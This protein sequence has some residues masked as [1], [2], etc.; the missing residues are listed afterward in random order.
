MSGPANRPPAGPPRAT[1]R[2]QLNEDFTFRDAARLAPYLAGLGIS[3]VYASPF[4]QARPGSTHGYD[5]TDHNR[6]NEEIGGEAEFENFVATLH[7]HGLGLLLDFVPNHMGIGADNA[8]WFDVLEWG[9]YSPY[10]PFF[11]IDW[12]ASRPDLKGKVLLPVLGGQYGTVLIDGEI[13]LRFDPAEGSISAWYYDHRFPISPGDYA[14]LL[15]PVVVGEEAS[16]QVDRI[17][18]EFARL[19]NEWSRRWRAGIRAEVAALKKELAELCARDPATCK[20]IADTVELVNGEKGNRR[21]WR[22]L[23]A[24]IERQ[25]YRLA[26]WRVASDEIN[27]RRFFNINDLAG[28]R[29]ELPELFERTHRLVFRL[30]GEG[31]IQG[32]RIDHIDGLYDPQGYCERLQA[33]YAELVGGDEPLCVVVEKI[34]AHGERLPAWP[35]AGTTGYEFVN[36]VGALF[37]DASSKDGLTQVY[38][39]QTGRD[40]S[41]DDVLYESKVRI[42]RVNLAS[43]VNVLARDFHRLSMSDWRTRDFTLNAMRFAL[44]EVIAALPIYRTYVSWRGASEQDRRFI[45]EAIATAKRRSSSNDTS[46]F[47]FLHRALLVEL[48]TARGGYNR[49][50]VLRAAMRFQQISGPVMAKGAEDTAFYRY[51]RLLSLNEVGGD[52]RQVG[53]EPAEFHRMNE[54]RLRLWP[55][56]LLSTSTHDTKRGED[57]RARISL[58]S[59]MPDEWGRRVARWR[60]LNAEHRARAAGEAVPAANDEYFFYQSL[61]GAWPLDLDPRSAEAMASLAERMKG[62]LTKAVREGKEQSSWTNPNEE[63]EAALFG[64]TDRVLAPSTGR[65][66]LHDFAGFVE[67]LA[68]LGALNSLAQ[69]LVKLTVP[70]IPDTYQGAELWDFSLVDPDNRRPVDFA[71]RA[72]LLEEVR[73]ARA[74]PAALAASWGDGREKLFLIWAA[75]ELR[76]RHPELFVQGEYLPLEAT[77][78]RA[79]HLCAFLRRHEGRSVLVVVPRLVA[80]LLGGSEAPDWGD[81][82]LELPGRSAWRDALSG[83]TLPAASRISARELFASFPV[84]LL[85]GD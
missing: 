17:V 23:H 9:E 18:D 33:K 30:I 26:Y 45:D 34:L 27:Y 5:I 16:E 52:P 58:I 72:R 68:R 13:R 20:T 69:T 37:V 19:E 61:L 47:D 31:K 3:H 6:S 29:V 14:E 32:L 4:L 43:E 85:A 56:S 10:A 21:S 36:Q 65:A 75:L 44:R 15:R 53:L 49:A 55:H 83:R 2:L 73:S 8:W 1:Y 70:G 66:F 48:G 59:E 11:D 81:T 78:A 50:D 67:R 25:S 22:Q 35:I 74:N 60:D 54:E 80:K 76:R 46:I 84:A 7:A 71:F 12:D 39:E 38:Q 24:V 51:V 28:I 64:F 40:A 62:L 77:G 79:D 63:Y 42:M 41:F 82:A 57:A